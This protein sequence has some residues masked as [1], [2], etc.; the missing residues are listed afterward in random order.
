M[1]RL[2]PLQAHHPMKYTPFGGKFQ[3]E[4]FPFTD[5]RHIQCFTDHL[6]DALEKIAST[7]LRKFAVDKFHS[8][9]QEAGIFSPN[10]EAEFSHY[11]WDIKKRSCGPLLR[12][13]AIYD[14]FGRAVP[15][16]GQFDTAQVA[17]GH[18]E[19]GKFGFAVIPYYSQSMILAGPYR[20][21]STDCPD[22]FAHR[23]ASS[24]LFDLERKSH[25]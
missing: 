20:V 8:E 13:F 16:G 17:R 21:R 6:E 2:K 24:L 3:V 4:G 1:R 15:T 5:R 14:M 23:A 9:L 10:F 19:A 25:S 12:I 18:I 11:A 7:D 22:L